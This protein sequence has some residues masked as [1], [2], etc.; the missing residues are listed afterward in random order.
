[1]V[2]PGS[3]LKKESSGL[4]QLEGGIDWRIENSGIGEPPVKLDAIVVDYSELAGQ[5]W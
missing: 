2:R 4:W 5:L 3:S 1:M